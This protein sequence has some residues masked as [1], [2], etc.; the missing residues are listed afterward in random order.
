MEIVGLKQKVDNNINK[1]IAKF[2][3]CHQTA[4]LINAC[5][6]E[7]NSFRDWDFLKYT[8]NT[9]MHWTYCGNYHRKLRHEQVRRCGGRCPNCDIHRYDLT[10]AEVYRLRMNYRWKDPY[11]ERSGSDSD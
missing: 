11:R 6:G 8:Y 1:L 2:V 7:Y 9:K 10:F 5:I 4:K 3:C